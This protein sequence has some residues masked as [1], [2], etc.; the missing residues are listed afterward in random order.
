[1]LAVLTNYLR[2]PKTV[3]FTI[4]PAG[5]PTPGNSGKRG[6][7]NFAQQAFWQPGNVNQ[8]LFMLFPGLAAQAFIEPPTTHQQGELLLYRGRPPQGQSRPLWHR[9]GGS[10]PVA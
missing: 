2:T 10:R 5:R 3:S 9:V 4:W 1:M 6:G 8:N 7:K